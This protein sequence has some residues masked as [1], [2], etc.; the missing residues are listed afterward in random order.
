MDRKN[1][2][3]DIYCGVDV[4]KSS[5]YIVAL[6]AAT[7]ERI[8]SGYVPQREDAIRTAIASIMGQGKVLVTVDQCGSFGRLTVAVARNMCVDIAHIPPS[9][10]KR[11]ADTYGEDKTD[12]KDAFII[13]DASRTTPRLI[14]LIGEREEA[15]EEIKVLSSRRDDIVK[16]RT[17]CYNRLHELIHQVC[18]PLEEQFSGQRLHYEVPIRLFEKYGGP[19]GFRQAGRTRVGKWAGS[20]KWHKSDGPRK[21]EE[22][23]DSLDKQ[24]VTLP[25]SDV[26]EGLI[27]KVAKRIIDLNSEE[28]E[29][30]A[31]LT[32]R[33]D[34][35]P[36]AKI[37]K[38]M[39]GIGEI[40]GAVIAAEIGDISRFPSAHHL[41][42]Y[43]GVAPRREESGTSVS[44]TK[45]RKGGN[46]RLKNALL[47]SARMA[48]LNDGKSKDY[49]QRKISEGKKHRQVLRALA[50]R[51][52]E[53][54]YAL[55]DTG[56]FYEP[57][58]Q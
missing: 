47:E 39:P 48:V 32:Q 5:N 14:R 33:A 11:I 24:A 19:N 57:L 7:E 56:S 54:I 4:G 10:Y 55:L 43:G 40:F 58:H 53:V 20:L 25:A 49:Y 1:M 37:L 31:A 13:A 8:F 44:K 28:K 16:E 34:K 23:F 42:S 41:A 9:S 52:V 30:R 36:E 22:I 15:I 26:I 3:Y 6:E 29:L 51:R 46:R 12:A 17:Q 2:D 45:K 18:P 50:R 21:A 38:S 35:L 27:K